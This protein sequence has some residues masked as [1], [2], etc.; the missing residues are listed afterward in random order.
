MPALIRGF[1][2]ETSEWLEQVEGDLRTLRD[3]PRDAAVLGQLFRTFH[4]IKGNAAW[5]S[6]P[7][8]EA[9]AHATENLLGAVRDDAVEASGEVVAAL[10]AATDAVR[11]MVAGLDRDGQ[12]P[13][14]DHAALRRALAD[15]STPRQGGARAE[16]EMFS[17]SPATET[18]VMWTGFKNS[19]RVDVATLDGL[20]ES[21]HHLAVISNHL[22]RHAAIAPDDH[23]LTRLSRSLESVSDYIDKLTMLARMQSLGDLWDKYPRLVRRLQSTTGKQFDL[24]MHGREIALDRTVIEAIKDPLTHLVRNAMVHGIEPPEARVGAGKTAA[25]RVTIRAYEENRH[26][27]IEVSDDGAGIDPERTRQKAVEMGLMSAKEAAALS[28]QEAVNLVFHP[29]FSLA[30][31]VTP[32]SGR[33]V[34][35]DVV[36]TNIE[37]LGG[38]VRAESQLGWGTAFLLRIPAALS[39]L[40][41]LVFRWGT[42]RFAVPESA[43]LE[44]VHVDTADRA[45]HLETI[46]NTPVYPL[47]GTPL[48]LVYPPDD[49]TGEHPWEYI[50]VLEGPELPFGVMVESIVGSEKT[51][52]RPFG[53]ADV[54][55]PA[56]VGSSAHGDGKVT[57]VLDPGGLARDLGPVFAAL[58]KRRALNPP[59]KKARKPAPPA[60]AT[61]R[62]EK[63]PPIRGQARR[64]ALIIDDSPTMRV[65]MRRMLAELGFDI[66]EA[67]NGRMALEVLERMETVDLI[68]CD[69]NMPEMS[70]IEFIRAARADARY[71]DVSIMMVSTEADRRKV[72]EALEAGADDYIRKPFTPAVI[73]KKVGLIGWLAE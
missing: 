57:W 6:L 36:R 4:S 62:P 26:V 47:R 15:L 35:M 10:F 46:R 33:G 24:R 70:G 49:G 68:M 18:P 44:I 59:T 21:A 55:N 12:E 43:L 65:L 72:A 14:K 28:Q 9:L 29:G 50:I 27:C 25:G 37:Q 52:V 42:C 34:G 16:G 58:K 41:T 67:L 20:L 22:K 56:I 38:T 66:T 30:S 45:K 32:L 39:Y 1:I 11:A 7:R 64:R 40:E 54:T 2:E 31:E 53:E 73:A 13:D 60:P 5:C 71:K 23:T 51:T 17:G 48:P 8:I 3:K 61:V 19:V 63:A 69:W